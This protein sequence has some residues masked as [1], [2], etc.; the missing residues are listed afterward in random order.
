MRHFYSI[1]Q[2]FQDFKQT[3]DIDTDYLLE[4]KEKEIEELKQQIPKRTKPL[5]EPITKKPE[6]FESDIFVAAKE[7]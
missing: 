7:G 5:F 3:V 6:D 2:K 4:Q 1:K